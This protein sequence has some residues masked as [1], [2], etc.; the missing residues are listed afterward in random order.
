MRSLFCLSDTSLVVVLL[1]FSPWSW[2]WSL[3]AL[4]IC[5]CFK[6]N[7]FSHVLGIPYWSLRRNA[8]KNWQKLWIQIPLTL[9]LG[10]CLNFPWLQTSRQGRRAVKVNTCPASKSNIPRDHSNLSPLTL[11]SCGSNYAVLEAPSFSSSACMPDLLGLSDHSTLITQS[12][13]LLWPSHSS[14]CGGWTS[15]MR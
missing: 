8:Q 12:N 14:R 9:T 6:M 15:T 13:P 2:H 5:L 11:P 10:C 3:Q 7:L 1:Q 4:P